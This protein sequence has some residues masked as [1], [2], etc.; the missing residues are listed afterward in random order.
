MKI[1]TLLLAVLTLAAC[2]N[3]TKNL[4]DKI[5]KMD[6]KLDAILAQRGGGGAAQPQ[7]PARPEPDRSKTYAVSIEGD[8]FIGSADAKITLVEAFDYA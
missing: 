3:D 2:Q 6:K 8:P 4:N 7:R 1:A 5:D